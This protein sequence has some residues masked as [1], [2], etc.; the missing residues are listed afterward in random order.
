M[1]K[2]TKI[3]LCLATAFIALGAI[4]TA[5]SMAF[6]VD[7]VYAFQSGML[8]FKV[9]QKRTSEFS[10]DGQYSVPADGITAL[11]ID[12][13]DGTIEVEVYDGSEIILQET[14][15]AALNESNSLMYTRE[16]NTLEIVSAP[17]QTGLF[18]SDTGRKK[19]HIYLPKNIE[20][21]RLQIDAQDTDISINSMNF[22]NLRV[23]VVSG[24]L[25]LSKVDLGCLTFSSMEGNMTAKDSQI[26]KI[27]AD[28]TSGGITA[29]LTNCPESIQFDTMSGDTK[30]YL[31]CDSTFMVQ[32][33]TISGTL[34]TDFVGTYSE[35]RFTVGNGNAQFQLST[36]N[37]SVQILKNEKK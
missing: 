8:D 36:T 13:L 29:S 20:W 27:N 9:E 10:V 33:D 12:W 37:G 28:T 3:L 31:P 32:M 34:D 30:L 5:G 22:Q 17:S 11:S 21:K 24:D 2:S 19:L 4:L 6:G 7:P 23:D 1:K 15:S 16:K 18:L 35:D 26:E 14:N 25:S